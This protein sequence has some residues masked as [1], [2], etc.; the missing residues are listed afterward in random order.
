MLCV[1]FG[2]FI[3]PQRMLIAL[4]N[5]EKVP[6]ILIHVPPQYHIETK[7]RVK[8]NKLTRSVEKPK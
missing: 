3:V 2:F 1:A 6:I 8:N 4:A 5:I 7:K